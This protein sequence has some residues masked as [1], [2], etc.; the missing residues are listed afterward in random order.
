MTKVSLF[1]IG[2][3]K[4]GTTWVYKALQE[5]PE[6][7]CPPKD[8][9]HYFDMYYYRGEEWYHGFFDTNLTRFDPTPSYI[10]SPWAAERIHRYNPEAKI[11]LC[12]RDPIERAFSHCWHE[13]KKG[14]YN[15]EFS[16]VFSNYDLYS[17]WLEPG[18]YGRQLEKFLNYFPREQTLCLTFD[19]LQADPGK[20]LSRIYA[21]A[22]LSDTQFTPSVLEKKVNEAKPKQTF[23][24]RLLKKLRLKGLANDLGKGEYNRG[25]APEVQ[26]ELYKMVKPEIEYTE[27]VARIDLTHW[28][29]K[30]EDLL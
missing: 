1:H 2:P 13:K 19:E 22:E 4:S 3:Q 26:K 21:F 24:T 9:I 14:K 30:Y 10:R 6:I 5:H 29:K 18:F 12:L 16:E 15:F 17:S 25:P 27:A 11:I 7:E 23:Y 20:Y 28:K 8:T